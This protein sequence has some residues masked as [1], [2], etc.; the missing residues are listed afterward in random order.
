MGED[1]AV[2]YAETAAE[3]PKMRMRFGSKLYFHTGKLLSGMR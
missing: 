2:L 1:D 3:V